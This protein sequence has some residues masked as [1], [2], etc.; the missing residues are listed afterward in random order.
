MKNGKSRPKYMVGAGASRQARQRMWCEANSK[1]DTR[2]SACTQECQGTKIG[3]SRPRAASLLEGAASLRRSDYLSIALSVP[4]PAAAEHP[5]G[6]RKLR[7]IDGSTVQRS[8]RHPVH[9]LA[10]SRT[11][12]RCLETTEVATSIRQGNS[13]TIAA[14]RDTS[15]TFCNTT[16]PV[17][18]ASSPDH[19]AHG[20]TYWRQCFSQTQICFTSLATTAAGA[21]V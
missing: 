9:Q 17:G 19:G 3:H 2:N 8:F 12:H 16:Q 10:A 7:L 15:R 11:T 4:H 13:W 1:H 18:A 20:C 6:S 5:F 14:S 21:R